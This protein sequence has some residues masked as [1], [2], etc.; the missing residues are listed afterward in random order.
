LQEFRKTA[1][2]LIEKEI[3][4]LEKITIDPIAVPV[5]PTPPDVR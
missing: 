2:A 5:P 1:A 3:P 4:F